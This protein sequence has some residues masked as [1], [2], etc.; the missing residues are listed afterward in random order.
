MLAGIIPRGTAEM[1]GWLMFEVQEISGWI[2]QLQV[3]NKAGK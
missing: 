2:L 3:E 1:K